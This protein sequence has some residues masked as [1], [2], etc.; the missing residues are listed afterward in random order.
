MIIN[1]KMRYNASLLLFGA[2]I[3]ACSAPQ[4]TGSKEENI[5]T[6]NKARE[7]IKSLMLKNKT[8]GITVN[9]TTKDNR[10]DSCIHI[11]CIRN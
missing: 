1:I 10:T 8:I 4:K 3:C 7:I 5:Q 6:K 9:K 2:L 11:K